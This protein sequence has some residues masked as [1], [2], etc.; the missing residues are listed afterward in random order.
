MAARP[1]PVTV[2]RAAGEVGENL[3][4]WRKLLGLT[5]EQVAD[6]A[7]ISRGTLR[8]L[9]HGDPGVSLGALLSVTRALGQLPQIPHALDPYETD[10][11]RARSDL[12]LPQRVRQ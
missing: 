4:S 8:R 6:R 11:G 5:A 12:R 2:R 7:G 9:E 3:A 10:L 1:L